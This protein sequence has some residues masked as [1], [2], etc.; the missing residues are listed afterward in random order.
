LR[1]LRARV[2][3]IV[4]RRAADRAMDDELRFHIDMET[5]KHVRAGLAPV[6][7]RRRAL[8]SFGGVERHRTRLREGRRLPLLEPLWDDT[9][10]G[11]RFVARDPALSLVAALTIALGVGSATTVFST[12]NA[13]FLRPLPIPGSERLVS[14]QESRSGMAPN[15]I[16]GMMIPYER[17]LSYRAASGDVFEALAAHRLEDAL[18]L[19]LP[20]ATVA[21]NGTLTSGNYFRAL[22]VRPSLGRAYD[23]DEADEIV[24]SHRLWTTRFGADT[25]AVGSMVGLEGRRM[26]VVGVAPPDFG[27]ATFVAAQVW[28]PVGLRGDDRRGWAT[29]VVPV[30]RLH[31]DVGVER[32]GARVG[33]L[34]L[35][36]PP[37]EA[38]T[39]HGATLERLAAV[40]LAIRGQAAGFFTIL[41]GMAL[42]VLLIASANIAG[43]MLARGCARRREMAVRMAIG[44]G[45]GRMV[46]HLLSESLL[47]FALGGALGVLLAFAGTAW[48]ARM[49]LPAQMP[50]MLLTV[51]PDL[52]VLAFAIA[53]TGVT[54]VVFGL[55]PAFRTSR[56]EL[57]PALKTGAEGGQG[58]RGS[59]RAVFVAGQIA[60]AVTL[61]L[62]A[63]LF[64]RSFRQGLDADLGFDPEGVVAARVDLSS[65]P[66]VD[67]GRA[68][69]V[70]G[71][72]LDRVRALPGVERAALSRYVLLSGA[73]SGGS[74]RDADDDAVPPVH[75]YFGSVGPGFFET[76]G[77]D[78]VAGRG[79]T[80]A[81]AEGAA[82][83]VVVNEA[84]GD[85]LWPGE[86]P[87]GKRLAI[88]ATGGT[89]DVVGV[90]R[91]GRY[92]FVTEEETPFFF[93][94][95]P[96]TGRSAVVV[97]VRAPG[98]EAVT[99][100]A[101]GE[102]VRALDPDLALGSPVRL[103]DLAGAGL[104]PQRFAAQ[105]VGAFGLVGLVLA[106][107]G[108]YGVLA[109]R[110]ALRTREIGVR[111][112]LGA[113]AARVIGGVVREGGLLAGVGC[114]V[115]V[116]AGGALAQAIRGFLY[117]I[118]PLDPV[119]FAVVPALLF[120]VAI[121]A[122]WV[123]ARR[124]SAIE[125]VVALRSD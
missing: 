107:L 117:G 41:L 123:P 124:A 29:R 25:A 31:A 112:A 113:T 47:L 94:P 48:I 3:D 54:G 40:P 105:L 102:A 103:G 86:S 49:E 125:A 96:K 83:V 109:Y 10:F 16:E 12:M 84:L 18:S 76:M 14:I 71:E 36:I 87:V 53:L 50:D 82:G 55:V 111:R 77:I 58:G 20:D 97:N 17:Y 63:T 27:G 118:H 4:F 69:T 68:S 57:V 60:L 110:V 43:V 26:R 30:G 19:R 116:L 72:L 75:A 21:V 108:V 13:L 45:R 121:L 35:G 6:E 61:L 92:R 119:T 73:V 51:S 38:T 93:L 122:S 66:D 115:G 8:A 91:T 74:A 114:A 101:L 78:L 67:R 106:A 56:T 85:R 52:V 9:R 37:D 11:A 15:G 81:D 98:A 80:D 64:V 33:A 1:G 99:L 120:S 62:T 59:L 28:A 5:E 24:I 22:G 90:T 39:V 2:R 95:H 79:F 100:Q 46:R 32:A 70:V 88:I 7:A 65:L 34:A 104:F 44:A 89:A 42:L 23:A